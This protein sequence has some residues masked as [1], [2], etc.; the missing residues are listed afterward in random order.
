[1]IGDCG[2]SPLCDDDWPPPPSKVSCELEAAN[3]RNALMSSGQPDPPNKRN[4]ESK[5]LLGVVADCGWDFGDSVVLA[6]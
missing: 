1:M 2:E 3:K 6:S 4:G 5:L